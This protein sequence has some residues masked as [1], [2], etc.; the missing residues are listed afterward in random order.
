MQIGFIFSKWFLRLAHLATARRLKEKAI[1][2]LSYKKGR[3][4][5]KPRPFQGVG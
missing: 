4:K 2:A 1:A 5:E 3:L